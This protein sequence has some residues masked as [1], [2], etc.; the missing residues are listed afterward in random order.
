M[1]TFCKQ[2]FVDISDCTFYP[3]MRHKTNVCLFMGS[4]AGPA[5]GTPCCCV[6]PWFSLYL[7]SLPYPHLPDSKATK[8]DKN[9]ILAAPV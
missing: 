6:F 1:M 9:S 3:D 4:L 5:A 8:I 7:P 2:P